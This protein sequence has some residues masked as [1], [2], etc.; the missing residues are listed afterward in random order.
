MGE[1]RESW[2][3]M[4][5]ETS[6]VAGERHETNRPRNDWT[7]LRDLPLAILAWILVIAIVLWAA[8]HVIGTILVLAIASLLAFALAPLVGW[9]SKVIPRPIATAVVYLVFFGLL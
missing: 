8:S 4:A 1:S 2:R 3:V 7:R 5:A 6:G 9:L